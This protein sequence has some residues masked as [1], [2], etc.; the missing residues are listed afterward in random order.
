M[1]DLAAL[2]AETAGQKV[3]FDLPSAA[4]QAGF[5]TATVA[6]LDSSKLKALGWHAEYD[7]RGGL[8]DTLASLKAQT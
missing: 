7:I 6:R 1:R 4:E 5:S 3:V 8:A 2:V